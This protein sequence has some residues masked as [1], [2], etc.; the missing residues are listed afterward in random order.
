M[1]KLL[2]TILVVSIVMTFSTTVFAGIQGTTKITTIVNPSYTVSIPVD[3][4]ITYGVATTQIGNIS[5][6]NANFE[7]GAS[8]VVSVVKTDLADSLDNTKKITYILNNSSPKTEF[9]GVTFTSIDTTARSLCIDITPTDWSTAKAGNYGATLTF[10][11]AYN[12]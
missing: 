4:N 5:I 12:N 10:N 1:K 11:I 7:T 9:T 8:V 3:T 6:S 2:S